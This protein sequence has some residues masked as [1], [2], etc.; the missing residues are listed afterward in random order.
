MCVY[1]KKSVQR[2]F[3]ELYTILKRL[4]FTVLEFVSLNIDG[5]NLKSFKCAQ[6]AD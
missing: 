3:G 2:N 6:L 4:N 5:Y 1:E